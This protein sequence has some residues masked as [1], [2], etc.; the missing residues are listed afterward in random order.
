MV[1]SI[2]ALA[3]KPP[4]PPPQAS[5]YNFTQSKSCRTGPRGFLALLTAPPPLILHSTGANSVVACDIHESLCDVARRAAIHNKLSHKI[6]VFHR[7]VGL[8]QRGKEVRPLGVNVVV[9]D[10]F[11]AGG[12]GACRRFFWGA[13]WGACMCIL[14]GMSVW[15]CTPACA[16]RAPFLPE[17]L[18]SLMITA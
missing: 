15:P 1:V 14:V 7:D 2:D 8:L 18:A 16:I 12:L 17:H 4:Q 13:G 5:V 9:A 3:S 11:D 6:S 10:V